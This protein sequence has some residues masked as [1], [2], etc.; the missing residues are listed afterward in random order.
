MLFGLGTL[1]GGND[2]VVSEQRGLVEFAQTLSITTSTL[3]QRILPCY[4]IVIKGL[5]ICPHH[6]SLDQQEN[7]SRFHQHST[8]HDT[9]TMPS[10]GIASPINDGA[11][12]AIS[13]VPAEVWQ[14]VLSYVNER[15][16]KAVVIANFFDASQ[17]AVR[18][19]WKDVT[20][21]NGLLERLY[22]KIEHNQQGLADHI[23]SLTMTFEAPGEQLATCSLVFPSLQTLKVVH[24]KRHMNAFNNTHVHIRTLIGPALTVLDIGTPKH[25]GCDSKP[26]VD[27][28]FP[29]LRQ[30]SNL[31][32][33][34]IRACVDGSTR[35]FVRAL[36]A[37]NKLKI[38]TLDKHTSSLITGDTMRALAMHPKL[39]TLKVNKEL[40]KALF[41]CLSSLESPFSCLTSLDVA[42]VADAGEA[43]LSLT[44]QLRSLRL[45]VCKTASIFPALRKLSLLERL[46]LNFEDFCMTGKDYKQLLNLPYLKH[47]ELGGMEDRRGLDMTMVC[48]ISLVN[49]LAQL[50]NLQLFRLSAKHTFDEDFIIALG[51]GCVNLTSLALSGGYKL[52]SLCQETGVLFPQLLHLEMDDIT[53]NDPWMDEDEE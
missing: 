17:Q 32:T 34:S 41:S 51:R 22:Q 43:L 21:Q 2:V 26:R 38:L 45:A 40:D 13:A 11:L 4:S 30:C 33:L 39:A 8:S 18:L 31:H 15:D 52:A 28:F 14:Q 42:L 27:N 24:N 5:F 46:E 44:P 10:N 50:S 3:T 1:R 37:C 20:I 49:V 7:H 36:N 19:F 35:D 53:N 25:E 47:L 9:R 6:L 48:D 16:L 12:R 23:T 29:A